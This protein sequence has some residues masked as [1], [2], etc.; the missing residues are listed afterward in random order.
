[1]ARLMPNSAGG[2]AMAGLDIFFAFL[3]DQTGR[4][5]GEHEQQQG[6]DDNVDQAGVE[7]LR[8]VALDQ[9]DDE[10]GDDG[11]FD[12]AE[13]ADNDDG[14]GL[15][16]DGGAGKGSEHQH[17]AEHGARSCRQAPTRSRRSA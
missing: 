7:K 1:M 9:P 15:D 10:P 5:H 12:I 6:K 16:D 3:G 14:E 8:G 11:A 13:A 17:R 2:S 4:P